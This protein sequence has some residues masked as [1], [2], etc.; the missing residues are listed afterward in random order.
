MNVGPDLAVHIKKPVNVSI[1]DYLPDSNANTMF[2]N[3]VTETEIISLVGAFG[4]KTSLD[5]LG[6]NMSLIKKVIVPIAKPLTHICNMSFNDGIFP[7]M[8][9]IAKVVPLFKSGKNNIFTNYRPV[10]LLPQFSKILEKLFNKRLDSFL[11]KFNILSENQ[12]GFR[13]NRSTS[14]A[15]MELVEDLTKSLDQHKHTI[16]VFIDLKKAFDTIDHKILLDKLHHYGLRG[17]ASNWIKSYLENRKQYVKFDNVESDYMD[18][19]C[20]VPQGSILG[21]KLFILYINDLCRVSKCLKFILFA[22]D[23]NI[24]CSGEDLNSLSKMVTNELDKLKDW[25]DVNRL[26]LNIS[27]TN[28]MIFSNRLKNTDLKIE[29]CNTSINRVNVTRFLGVLIDDRLTWK[30]QISY[31]NS[32]VSK[33]MFLLN[34]AKHVL[35]YDALLTLYN[36][37][38][39]PYLTYCCEL[40]GSTYK[41]RLRSTI[42][43][44]KKI[45]RIIH[46][47]KYRDHTSVFFYESKLLKLNEL[48][49]LNVSIIMYKAYHHMLPLNLQALFSKKAYEADK[50]ATRQIN[51][52]N[53][54]LCRTTLKQMCITVQGVKL[55]NSLSEDIFIKTKTIHSFK[56]CMKNK[57]IRSYKTPVINL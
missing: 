9:K 44:Q 45:I 2:L 42:I 38:V 14:L 8:M 18:V 25:F 31:V 26:S 41:S 49:S 4:H 39:L 40:W 29:I 46:G 48:I 32:K 15:L 57:F 43:L 36:C 16:G 47:A 10:S 51:K 3:P 6:V 22:D 21:P 20:G 34:R 30:R 35:N 54:P 55:W 37:I 33:S 27:K 23:T 56:K 1:R 13:E 53:L 19:K 50:M 5:C 52:F 7:D 12:Y 24:F 28:Y 17:T 11:N